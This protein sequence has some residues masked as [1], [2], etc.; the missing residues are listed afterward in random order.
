MLVIKLVRF[1]CI[2]TMTSASPN[3]S[4]RGDRG[5]S[6][7]EVT[8]FHRD[9][10][11]LTYL[12]RE[13]VTGCSILAE[14]K[15]IRSAW[16]L[17]I[18]REKPRLKELIQ[19][20]LKMTHYWNHHN[21]ST[22]GTLLRCCIQGH[23]GYKELSK[24]RKS[25][26]ICTKFVCKSAA[27]E[28]Q[29][30]PSV[31]AFSRLKNDQSFRAVWG[32]IDCWVCV[33]VANGILWWELIQSL[34]CTVLHASFNAQ[35]MLIECSEVS[36]PLVHFFFLFLSLTFFHLLLSSTTGTSTLTMPFPPQMA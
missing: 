22:I 15:A 7:W 11:N 35:F 3:R 16:D 34:T 9:C 32:V 23:P 13:C 28:L 8:C 33:E 5:R 17:W 12:K 27:L 30:S 25:N 2:M 10:C 20:C 26:Q 18:T 36:L 14:W 4:R 21:F 19:Y 31:T 29:L 6:C 24:V 1:V